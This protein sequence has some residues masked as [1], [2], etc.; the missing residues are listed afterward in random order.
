MRRKRAPARKPQAQTPKEFAPFAA[1]VQSAL[2]SA[3]KNVQK[4]LR[5]LQIGYAGRRLRTMETLTLGNKQTLSLVQVDGQDY[6]IGST[7]DTMIL[8]AKLSAKER[9][10]VLTKLR[11]APAGFEVKIPGLTAGAVSMTRQPAIANANTK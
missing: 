10:A 2:Q 8:L 4:V 9:T 5:P 11:R 3:W 6:L 1:T 7:G